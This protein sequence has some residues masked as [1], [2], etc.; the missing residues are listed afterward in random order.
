MRYFDEEK[1]AA[2]YDRRPF[3][4]LSARLSSEL[5]QTGRGAQPRF[6]VG[7]CYNRAPFGSVESELRRSRKRVLLDDDNKRLAASVRRTLDALVAPLG[8]SIGMVWRGEGAP[9]A[10]SV[11]DNQLRLTAQRFVD[12]REASDAD[13]QSYYEE[14]CRLFRLEPA[15]D[16]FPLRDSTD[17][18]PHL[19]KRL[20]RT[21]VS[22]SYLETYDSRHGTNFADRARGALF[23]FTNLVIKSD[24]TV[25]PLEAAA[26]NEFKQTLYPGEGLPDAEDADATKGG[27]GKKGHG[28]RGDGAKAQTAD[29]DAV[30]PSEEELPPP[31]PLEELLAELDALV[32]LERVKADVRQLINFLK[33]QKLREEQGLKTLPASRHLVFYGNPGTGKTTVARLLAQVYRTL[34]VLRRGHLCETDRAG[35]VAGYVGQT[36][37][38]VRE[39]TTKALGGVLFIDEAY[40]LASGGS[41]DFGQEAVETLLKMMEDHRDD[42]VVIVAGY[43]GRM[44][45]F[46]DSNPGLRSRFNKHVHF[47]D[48][49]GVQLVEIFKTFCGK[50]DFRLAE[51]AEQ[52]LAS[53]FQVLTASRD[54]TFGNARTA[55]NLFEAT[56]SKQ[57]NRLVSLPKVDKDILSTIESADIPGHEE[58]RACGILSDS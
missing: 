44:Q 22:V 12:L 46:L 31:R 54:E 13:K 29:A 57:A 51:G 45:G 20:D 27:A 23:Q 4:F 58:L 26:L 3:R 50:A 30:E 8:E 35:L 10:Q 47:D 17:L 52:A 33:V 25:T 40:T 7:G 5:Q 56:L 2:G 11:L 9:Q 55:R 53:V 41:N 19:L 39:V 1:R 48:Y 38:K 6:A 18:P 16:T 43:T 36:A 24:G 49:E 28:T 14:V 32:G 42:L 21:P 15:P 37:M 34:G